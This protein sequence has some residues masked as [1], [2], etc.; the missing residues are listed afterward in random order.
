M[1]LKI[2]SA[3][4]TFSPIINKIFDLFL[5][6]FGKDKDWQETVR[7]YNKQNHGTPAEDVES[8]KILYDR[9]NKKDDSK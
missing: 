9:L 3:L 6:R 7:A 1:I 8:V 2:L 4:V 5:K